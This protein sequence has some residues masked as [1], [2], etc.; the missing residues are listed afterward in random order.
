MDKQPLRV[1]GEERSLFT[2]E[3]ED[4]RIIAFNG[5]PATRLP[6][7]AQPIRTD[8]IWFELYPPADFEI[9]YKIPEYCVFSTYARAVVSTS[10]NDGPVSRVSFTAGSAFFAPPNTVVRAR[11][12]T[13]VEFLVVA[14]PPEI[15]EPLFDRAAHGRILAPEPILN[16][17]D[18]G[19][20]ALQLEVRR[21][22]L[23]DPLIEPGYLASLG[24]SILSRVGCFIATAD[25]RP[26]AKESLPPG[27]LKRLVQQIEADLGERISVKDLARSAGLSRSHFSRA[28][29]AVTGNSPQ[30]FIILRR[31]C[32]ARDLLAQS[33]RSIAE[34]AAETGFASHAHLSTLFKKRL[35]VGPA[36]YRKSF[37]SN[38]E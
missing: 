21:S 12:E 16:F 20:A 11:M 9:A 25:A 19:F 34:I 28:F 35:G 8:G 38:G 33:D 18:P 3:V 22:L 23:G 32:R 7:W 1:L 15:A 4:N 5:E 13:P 31:L 26:D 6:G 24:Q 17:A 27:L 14:A 10:I 2:R 36:A 29:Q 30:E 37:K